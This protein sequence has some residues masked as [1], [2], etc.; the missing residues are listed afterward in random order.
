M[1]KR[2]D[3][4]L[5][6]RKQLSTMKGKSARKGPYEGDDLRKQSSS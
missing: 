6:Q 3:L 2:A 4:S 1:S 5:L